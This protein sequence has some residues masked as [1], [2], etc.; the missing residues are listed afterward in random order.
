MMYGWIGN[1][2][3]VDLSSGK[4]E[5]EDASTY[6]R[7]FIGGRGIATA[8]A[9]NELHTVMDPFMPE[10]RLIFMT[11]PLT[12]LWLRPLGEPWSAGSPLKHTPPRGSHVLTWVDSGDQN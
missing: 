2:L 11:G 7:K 1:I 6:A 8:I 10:N 4:T 9:W 3:R 5:V 12:G